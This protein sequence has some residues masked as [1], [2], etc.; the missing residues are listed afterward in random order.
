VRGQ[1]QKFAWRD[2]LKTLQAKE[3]ERPKADGN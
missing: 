1:G 3:A 2:V